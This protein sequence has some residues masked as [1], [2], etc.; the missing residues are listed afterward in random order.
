MYKNFITVFYLLPVLLTSCS[1]NSE[2][3]ASP[4]IPSTADIVL[5]LSINPSER[6]CVISASFS[7]LS[8]ETSSLVKSNYFNTNNTVFINLIKTLGTGTLRIGGNSSDKTFWA[9]KNRMSSTS[10]DSLFKE[11]LDR[12]FQ[13][14]R[15]TG[16]KTIFGLNVGTGDLLQSATE[17]QYALQSA[18]GNLLYFELGNEP[19]LY[20]S[21]GLRPTSY[22][23]SNYQ[24]D[25]NN[26][27]QSILSLSPSSQFSGPASAYNTN[28]FTIPFANNEHNNIALLTQHYYAMGP[29][30]DP[31]VT[32]DR[33][34]TDNQTLINNV[35]LLNGT[36]QTFHFNYR[37]AECNSVYNGGQNGVSNT[38]ASALWGADFMFTLAINGCFGVN[39]HG[40]GS[41]PYSPI[42]FTNNIFTARPLFYGMLLFKIASQGQFMLNSFDVGTKINC[43]E[44]TVFGNDGRYYITIINKDLT[45]EVY[46]K[47]TGLPLYHSNQIIRLNASSVTSSDGI[48]LGNNMVDNNGNWT[49]ANSEMAGVDNTGY[50]LKIPPV[51]IALLIVDK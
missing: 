47:V 33:L 5:N 3:T 10:A 2:N 23:V 50:Q 18:D 37:I 8:F 22:T 44:Y 21:N 36:S 49:N 31:S 6:G 48:K 45:N 34:L 27:K 39:F 29:A 13:F 42:A 17:A 32:I 46:L 26:Y 35:V 38:L 7:G 41:G 28:G 15:A 12:Y 30:G 40:G 11:D 51:S 25:F 43:K 16:W 24:T 19:D 20:H 9:N 4:I 1:K 14:A